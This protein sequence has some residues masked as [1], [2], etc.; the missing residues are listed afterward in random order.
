MFLGI[1][2][3][4]KRRKLVFSYYDVLLNLSFCHFYQASLRATKE[5]GLQN[6][7]AI[8]LKLFLIP[9]SSIQNFSCAI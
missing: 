1:N 3:N 9:S 6:C 5:P 7:L 2:G 4:P 8:L